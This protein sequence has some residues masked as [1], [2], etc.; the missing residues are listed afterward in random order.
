MGSIFCLSLLLLIT[1]M[2]PAH[3]YIDPGTGSMLLQLLLGGVAGALVIL[4]L[5]W[6]RF[7][8][9]FDRGRARPADAQGPPSA[10]AADQDDQPG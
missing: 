1:A 6:S 2:A 7:R 3:A 10:V 8:A 4:K 9:W 5:Y